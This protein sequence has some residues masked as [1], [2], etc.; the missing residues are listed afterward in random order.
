MN[1]H[2]SLCIALPV[3][4]EISLGFSTHA[5]LLG[6]MASK[7]GNSTYWTQWKSKVALGHFPYNTCSGLKTKKQNLKRFSYQRKSDANNNHWLLYGPLCLYRG[8][9][10]VPFY[11][12]FTIRGGK[13]AGNF[14]CLLSMGLAV[15]PPQHLLFLWG[16]LHGS[17]DVASF[18]CARVKPVNQSKLVS[19]YHFSC[20]SDW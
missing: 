5:H 2:C 17:Q 9:S 11:F 16:K 6:V 20:H 19:I 18:L 1:G 15:Y 10:L 4:I 8:Y 13:T 14:G 3:Y 12:S 7:D